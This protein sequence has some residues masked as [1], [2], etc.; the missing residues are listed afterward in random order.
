[1]FSAPKKL[2]KQGA[3]MSIVIRKKSEGICTFDTENINLAKSLIKKGHE[4]ICS[5]PNVEN[6]FIFHFKVT[7]TVETDA[8]DY[9]ARRGRI[10][11]AVS[12]E[13]TKMITS[14]LGAINDNTKR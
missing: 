1:L 8:N 11:A 3:M 10:D 12:R 9:L 4:V 2:I 7:E 14:M 6:G 5:H 13:M